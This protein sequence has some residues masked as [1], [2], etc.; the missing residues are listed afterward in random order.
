MINVFAS[1]TGGKGRM[2]AAAQAQR[3]AYSAHQSLM[4]QMFDMAAGQV[5]NIDPVKS[6]APHPL[7]AR[8]AAFIMRKADEAE[9]AGSYLS[10]EEIREYRGMI[11]DVRGLV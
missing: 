4:Y 7:A 5:S 6:P 2:K 8:V 11:E 9:R 10:D 1:I 3:D